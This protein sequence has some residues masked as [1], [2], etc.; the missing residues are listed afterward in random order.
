MSPDERTAKPPTEGEHAARAVAAE[1][2]FVSQGQRR[3]NLIWER[4]Q[5]TIALGV[6]FVV[7]ITACVLSLRGIDTTG[8]PTAPGVAGFVFLSS[9]ANLVIGFYF[10][11]TN[12]SRTGGIGSE[13]T[14]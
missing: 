6:T 12:H 2:G 4:T 5:A 10:G 1:A 3:I 14:R 9:V 7:L 8:N 13:Q 11:R